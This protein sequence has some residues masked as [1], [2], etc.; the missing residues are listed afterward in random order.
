MLQVQC[1]SCLKIVNGE[2]KSLVPAALRTAA[3]C[4]RS[5]HV[6]SSTPAHP[7]AC[8]LTA[9]CSQAV[10]LTP[11]YWCTRPC[12]QCRR[13]TSTSC[14]CTKCAPP[15]DGWVCMPCMSRGAGH[16]GINSMASLPAACS[17]PRHRLHGMA[18]LQSLCGHRSPAGAAAW[19]PPV[20]PW[21]RYSCPHCKSRQQ[22]QLTAQQETNLRV[23]AKQI[24]AAAQQQQRQGAAAAQQQRQTATAQLAA[25]TR[26]LAAAAAAGAS[27]QPQPQ[28]VRCWVL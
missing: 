9:Q 17:N 13:N 12:L 1:G 14:C 11:P 23:Q 26:A 15:V 6:P 24:L 7:P 4:C 20:S 25:Y 18:C 5:T 2:P 27:A 8:Q 22:I 3:S 28:A 16:Y 19:L 10:P 21:R